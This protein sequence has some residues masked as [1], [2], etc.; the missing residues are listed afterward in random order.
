MDRILVVSATD[1]DNQLTRFSNGGTGD[2]TEI[3]APGDNI[4]SCITGSSYRNMSGTSMAA[5][6]VTAVCG[7]T[8]SANKALSGAQVVDLV[9]GNT[10]VTAATNSTADTNGGMGIVDANLAVSA[11]VRTRGTDYGYVV[12]ATNNNA[13]ANA[14]VKLHKG[15][16]NGPLAGNSGTYTC[17]S[18]GR[19]T[20]PELPLGTYTLEISAEGYV[21]KFSTWTI[22]D[23]GITDGMSLN[24]GTF[25]LTPLMNEGQYRIVLSWGETPSD[26]D[27]HLTANLSD[28]S[29]YHVYYSQKNPSPEYANLDVDDTSSY[30][31]ETVTITNF[32]SLYNKKY[33]VHDYTNRDSSS[34]SELSKSDATVAVYKGEQLLRTFHVPTNTGGTEWDVFAFDANGNI[35]SINSM[36]YCSSPSEV[37]GSSTSSA[38]AT[39][40]EVP[41]KDYEKN[42]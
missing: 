38:E 21:T 25:A 19:F 6:M 3:A 36:T 11:A 42:P 35:V 16:K 33:A 15:N 2:L 12:D 29:Q 8:W 1:R 23:S 14:T 7:L 32:D 13:L 41:L 28:S 4:Y 39:T 5:P 30:G 40:M 22:I 18:S 34:S 17:D 20:L 26:L 31:P 27:S 9:M 10:S 24:R 37:L